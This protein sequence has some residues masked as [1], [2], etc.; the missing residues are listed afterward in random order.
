LAS[1]QEIDDFLEHFGVKGMHWG[2]RKQRTPERI[3]KDLTK[4]D[5]KRDSFG[6]KIIPAGNV[7][8]GAGARAGIAKR[9]L[10]YDEVQA[11]DGSKRLVPSERTPKITDQNRS[12]YEKKI[13]RAAYRKYIGTGAAVTATLLTAAYLGNT[14]ISDPGVSDLVTKGALVLAGVQTLQTVNVSWGIHRNISDRA[15][16]EKSKSLKNELKTAQRQATN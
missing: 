5:N 11:P 8:A 7:V 2:V 12:Q 13:D 1:E 16:N 10:K 3:Q 14:R 9:I 4:I 6:R 15:L